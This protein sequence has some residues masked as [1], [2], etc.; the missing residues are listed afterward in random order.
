MSSEQSQL[1]QTINSSINKIRSLI[2]QDED[3]L[4]EEKEKILQ[5][6]K[7]Y[8]S[9]EIAQIL[10]IRKPKELLPVQWELEELIEILDPPKPKKKIED[11]DDPKNRRL[12]QS[13]LEVVY[14]NPQAQMQVLASKV[15]DRMVVV[16]I[17]PYGQMVQNEFAGQEA[18]DLR[19]RIGL[20]PYNPSS[21]S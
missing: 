11:D 2:D 18:A 10:E 3:L 12:R 6:T 20:P 15:D 1:E 21:N 4:E 5:L 7:E 9:K 8:G 13:E 19:R 14:T 16:G 17:D